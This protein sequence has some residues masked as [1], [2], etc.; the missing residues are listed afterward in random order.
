MASLT[1][2]EALAQV[3]ARPKN[4]LAWFDL[5]MILALEDE[6]A[7]ARDCFERA[8]ALDPHLEEAREALE[9]LDS[10][11][12]PEPPPLNIPPVAPTRGMQPSD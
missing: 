12:I 10:P 1:R 8:L 6:D 9:L 3:R 11:A 2:D 7:K 4:P 5:G